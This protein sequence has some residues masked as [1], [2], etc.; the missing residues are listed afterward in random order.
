MRNIHQ[1]GLAFFTFPSATHNRFCHSLG[2]AIQ[3]ENL[4]QSLNKGNEVI[5]P[6][7]KNVLRSAA[8][9]HDIGHGPF[10][11]ISEEMY[12]YLPAFRNEY[13]KNQA[14]SVKPKPH[15]VLGYLIIN[16]SYFQERI[17]KK[18][19]I[20]GLSANSELLGNSIIGKVNDR[21][22]AYKVELINGSFDADKLDY[23]L[24]DGVASGLPLRLDLERLW[25]SIS[26][27]ESDF[28][29]SE[30]EQ[31]I[32]AKELVVNKNSV[33]ILEQIVFNKMNLFMSFY[34]HQKIRAAECMYKSIIE[35]IQDKGY[36]FKIKKNGRTKEISFYDPIDF[37]YFDD[38]FFL[39]EYMDHFIEDPQL[40]YLVEKLKN[41]QL[42]VRAAVIE[43]NTIDTSNDIPGK[44]TRD[45]KL[46]ALRNLPVKTKMYEKHSLNELRILTEE[47]YKIVKKKHSN[48]LKNEI[49]IDVP[50]SPSFT[51]SVKMFI[52]EKNE[53]ENVK[54]LNDYFRADVWA[55]QYKT[56]KYK[57]NVFCPLEYRDAVK[58]AVKEV[59]KD[60]FEIDLKKEAFSQ[61][62]A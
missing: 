32:H 61:C 46:E 40:N 29:Y 9:L 3:V 12:K 23:I 24:R 22:S 28:E 4:I 51:D 39:T 7:E 52:D 1:T 57:I 15:E 55:D 10:S 59:L 6:E 50:N 42:W 45:S 26:V 37:L 14:F 19:N 20:P 30:G 43:Y 60:K 49:W 62:H 31:K 56:N 34:H 18:I 44:N 36:I 25:F 13:L 47:I 16:S 8:L 5:S 21:M 48:C 35:Y 54:S 17:L 11:H 41:R 33:G 27:K 58:E 53:A 2:V 38:N